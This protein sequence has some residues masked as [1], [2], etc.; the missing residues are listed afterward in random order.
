MASTHKCPRCGTEYF[1]AQECDW[2]P[3]V[4]AQTIRN[5]SPEDMVA[6]LSAYVSQVKNKADKWDAFL[7]VVHHYG[8]VGME[9]LRR[10]NDR[11]NFRKRQD[12]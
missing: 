2:C 7:M 1:R 11:V 12:R 4:Q 6:K 3:G 5:I 9:I 8:T 10:V